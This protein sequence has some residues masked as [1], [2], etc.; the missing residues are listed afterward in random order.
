M[1]T[2]NKLDEQVLADCARNTATRKARPWTFSWA[3]SAGL[4]NQTERST[5]DCRTPR[6]ARDHSPPTMTP[7]GPPADTQSLLWFLSAICRAL[8]P[9]CVTPARRYCGLSS[10]FVLTVVWTSD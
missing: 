4:S 9:H 10:C 2:N 5:V 1:T 7:A 3:A 8:L 6:T